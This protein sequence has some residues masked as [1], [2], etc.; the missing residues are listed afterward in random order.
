MSNNVCVIAA[1][2]AK[3]L[4]MP[5]ELTDKKNWNAIRFT[6]MWRRVNLSLCPCSSFYGSPE[7]CSELY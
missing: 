5:L 4:T 1:V 6:V 2:Y 3:Y 7:Q